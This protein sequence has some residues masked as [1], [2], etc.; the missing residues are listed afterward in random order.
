MNFVV[1]NQELFKFD[2]VRVVDGRGRL[3]PGRVVAV[4]LDAEEDF[5]V[6]DV[7]VLEETVPVQGRGSDMG[8]REAPT[9]GRLPHVL[10]DL[11]GKL[12]SHVRVQLQQLAVGHG[13]LSKR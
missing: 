11:L 1:V 13:R 8:R 5:A 4:L 9:W 12:A 3:R 2:Q 7:S 10:H 6:D